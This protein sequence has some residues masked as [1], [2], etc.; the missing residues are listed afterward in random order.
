MEGHCDPHQGSPNQAGNRRF[1]PL[2]DE[3]FS[4]QLPFLALFTI[5]LT[6]NASISS[7]GYG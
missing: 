7:G 2:N 1:S 4:F 5:E 3:D 6:G